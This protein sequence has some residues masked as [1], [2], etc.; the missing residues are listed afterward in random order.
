MPVSSA[1]RSDQLIQMLESDPNNALLRLEAISASLRAKQWERNEQL[2]HDGQKIHP[3]DSV[4]HLKQAELFMAQEN[5]VEAE[6][7]LLGLIKDPKLAPKQQD[8]VAYNLAWAAFEQGIFHECVS[9]LSFRMQDFAFSLAKDELSQC[10]WIRALH[11]DKQLKQIIDW[12]LSAEQSNMLTS[13]AAGIAAL[14]AFDFNDPT[15]ASRWCAMADK[16]IDDGAATMEHLI[17]GSSLAL[18][19]NDRLRARKLAQVAISRNPKDGRA[20][21]AFAFI[22]LLD[23]EMQDALFSFKQAL[24]FMP[25][26]IGTWHGQAWT[27]LLTGDVTAATASFEQALQMDRNFAETH[28]G[29]AVTLAIQ[30]KTEQARDAIERA[31]RL[32]RSN[33]SSHYAAA[34]LKGNAHDVEAMKKLAFRLLSAQGSSFG[35]L[36]SNLLSSKP[37]GDQ[38]KASE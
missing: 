4:W 13:H 9:H 35:S 29:L 22:Q 33:L 32:D 5:W 38:S 18:A 1:P 6:S 20:W 16:V 15:T 17:V 11:R 3:N 27:Q 31:Q 37:V 19:Q 21:S 7:T 28:G 8:V 25:N 23:R 24:S 12:T 14:A 30:G 34:L 26:H 36:K 2:V 10:L